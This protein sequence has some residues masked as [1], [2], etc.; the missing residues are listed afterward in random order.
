MSIPADFSSIPILDY[1]LLNSPLVRTS[2]IT[3]LRHTLVN[4]RFLYLSNHTVSQTDIDLLIDYIP[5][6]FALPQEEKDKI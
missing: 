5:K 4:V 6:L 1:S 2:S 3:Q